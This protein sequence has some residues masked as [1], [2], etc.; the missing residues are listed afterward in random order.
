MAERLEVSQEDSMRILGFEKKWPKLQND[1]FTTFRFSRRDKDWGVTE[2]VQ[3][4]INP[5]SRNREELGTAR[6]V[7]KMPLRVFP[8]S[9][10]FDYR[11][12][13]EE[14]AVA[15]GFPDLKAMQLWM[16]HRYKG[17]LVEE[18]MNKL[19]LEWESS[20]L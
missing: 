11:L 16:W 1:S 13:T 10:P 14:E 4:V 15:D 9:F 3:I 19:T 7:N 6:I 18:P 12:V 17:R 5:R 2:L 8:P 20:K